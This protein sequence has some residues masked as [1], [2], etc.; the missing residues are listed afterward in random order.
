MKKCFGLV[1]LLVLSVFVFQY[2]LY[3]EEMAQ[4]TKSELK[5]LLDERTTLTNELKSFKESY[6]QLDQKYQDL[7]QKFLQLDQKY[8][9]LE[10]ESHKMKIES[11]LRIASLT[12]L[13]KKMISDYWEGFLIGNLTGF[14]IGFSTG[15]YLGVKLQ[16]K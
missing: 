6:N 13:Q 9:T 10:L 11:D 3:S 8:Q 7:N 1:L 2:S 12:S 15:G 4:I 14:G 16:F 5:T